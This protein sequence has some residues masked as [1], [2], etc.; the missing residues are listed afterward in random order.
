MKDP[1]ENFVN[2]NKQAFDLH[3]PNSKVWENIAQHTV[4]KKLLKLHWL[5]YVAA[6]IIFLGG[7]M[8]GINY[9]KNSNRELLAKVKHHKFQEQ[10]QLIES[11][12]YYVT[13]INDR[14]VEL[15]PYFASDP[16]L[17]LDIDVDFE[18]LDAFCMQLKTDLED[19]I[20]NQYVVEAMIQSYKMKL[21]ILE[22]LLNQLKQQNNEEISIDL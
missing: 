9:H 10:S 11:E 5:K 22:T 12:Y 20:N 21:E 18:E 2:K 4:K 13:K 1:I 3:E 7:F 15:E 14:L 19:D 16:Q 8:L 17:K 6:V